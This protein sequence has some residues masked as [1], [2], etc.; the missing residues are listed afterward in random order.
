MFASVPAF[1][2]SP[3]IE[4]EA[5]SN[6]GS[7]SATVSAQ[8]GAEGS[9]ATYHAEYGID[10]VDESSTPVASIGAPESTVD[11]SSQLTGLQPGEEYHFRFVATNG[12]NE[13]TYGT[14]VAFTTN[15]SIGPSTSILPDERVYELVSPPGW[16][17]EVYNNSKP[18]QRESDFYTER[19]VFQA[20]PNG[21][22]LAYVADPSASEGNG[23]RGKGVGNQWLARR[24][25]AGWEASDILPAG[26]G[27][28]S[29]QAVETRYVG[30][31]TD[32]SVG[33]L[34]AKSPSIASMAQ[35]QGPSPC[36][37]LYSRASGGGLGALFTSSVTPR[38]CGRPL[39]AGASADGSQIFFQTEARLTQEAPEIGMS[40]EEEEEGCPENC[41]LYDSV[42]GGLSLV[43]I[44]PEGKPAGGATFGGPPVG[45]SERAALQPPGLA[46][47]V[48]TDASRVFWTDTQAGP[49]MEHI[50]VRENGVTTVA[51]SEGAARYWTATSDGH[52][53]F[54]TEGGKLLRFDTENGTREVL[55][56]VGLKG[57]GAGVLGVIGTSEDGSYVYFVAEGALAPGAEPRVCQVAKE[58]PQEQEEKEGV[59]SAGSGCNLYFLHVGEAPKLVTV[60][61]A[62]DNDQRRREYFCSGCFQAGDWQSALA[63]RTAE[64]APDGQSV[65]FESTRHLTG[66]DSSVVGYG[67]EVFVYEAGAE[68]LSCVSCSPTGAPPVSEEG[69][70]TPFSSEWF[71]SRG[72]G[73]YLPIHPGLS[74]AGETSMPHW[75]SANGSRVF[76][77]ASQPLVPQDTNGLQDVY[78]WE[79]EGSSSCSAQAS[80]RYDGGCVFL[81]SSGESSDFSYLIDASTSGDDVFLSTRSQL[82]AQDGN[83]KVDVYDA[84]VDGGFPEFKLACTGSG[85]Q[86]VPPAPP[87]FA[88]PSSVTFTGVGNF[89]STQKSAVKPKAKLK[90]CKK[91][92][93]R[94]Q[95][96]CVKKKRKKVAKR[97]KRGR[98]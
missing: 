23:D 28:S 70:G 18:G 63:A 97:S 78:E 14:E 87:I 30:F 60:L 50:Y 91:G 48:S 94:K 42:G 24:S 36:S 37:V 84:R 58:E 16:T 17:G 3:T 13:T 31:S 1:A 45:R 33:I 34:T 57:E 49:D 35:P 66:Y 56:G 4:G 29:E 27:E 69:R 6:V 67:I 39:Y 68:R 86:G 75:L 82:A 11:V 74:G 62:I 79:R 10:K 76:F 2:A 52:Y 47:A 32:F 22:A 46:N 83:D 72:L 71:N 25:A 80:A 81:L 40:G 5:F 26:E 55:A 38:H 21:E 19:L 65:V 59:P 90:A 93:A 53:A 51:V 7:T 85:C 95:G 89:E 64:V 61:A 15:A 12:L 77:V 20:A 96:R 41:D 73:S 8:I 44:L 54:Y 92:F 98:N 88:T 9:P 43:D